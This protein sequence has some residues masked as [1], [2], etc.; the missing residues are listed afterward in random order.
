MQSNEIFMKRCVQLAKLGKGQVA[1]NPL[2]G[3]V[4]VHQGKVIGEGYHQKYGENHAE[5]NA[6]NSVQ[7]KTLLAESTIY[8]SLEPCAHTGKT[9]PCANLLVKHK[10]KK[11]VIGSRDS[12]SKVNGKGIQILIDAGIEVQTGVLEK[13]CLELNKHFFTFHSKQRPYVLLK[14]AETS[15]G[16]IDSLNNNGEVTWISGK[17]TQSFVHELRASYQSILVGANTVENDNPSLTVRQ[18]EG[19][20]PI[21]IVIDPTL[22]L[23][24][25]K[26]IFNHNSGVLVIN[27]LKNEVEG[28]IRWLKI[29]EI[30]PL[31]I[32]NEI[33]KQGINSVL[34]EGGA[35]TLQSFIDSNLW[36]EAKRIIGN[37][38]FSNGTKA[39]HLPTQTFTEIDFFDDRIQ[40]YLNS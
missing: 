9:P 37:T 6:V 29:E 35:F 27:K 7:D 25:S 39:P 3:A 10:F 8:V 24:P 28:H 18:V 1:P 33:Y 5:V 14:W 13:E 16:H 19:K 12:H 2:V 4:I 17:E 21:R 36:D 11:V 15:N 38:T 20:D 31:S 23:N 26:R 40:T 32:L 34:I 30:N 22:R